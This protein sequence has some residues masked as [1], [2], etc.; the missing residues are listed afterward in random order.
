MLQQIRALG[1]G[2]GMEREHRFHATRKWR[3]DFAWPAQMWALEVD[4]GT[5]SG[6]R[7]VRP[8]AYDRDCT[9]L[10]SAL[11]LGWRVLRVTGSHVR[12]GQAAAWLEQALRGQ[13]ADV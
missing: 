4:G 9:K 7:H 10:N 8:L 13:M 12:D 5:F 6:G 3:F 11:L 2:A 1:L